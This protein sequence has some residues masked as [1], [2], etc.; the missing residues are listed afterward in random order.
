MNI[1]KQKIKKKVNVKSHLRTNKKTL[2]TTIVQQHQRTD[3]IN[4][5]NEY[6]KSIGYKPEQN[7]VKN[8]MDSN[9]SHAK[10]SD[11]SKPSESGI[12]GIYQLLIENKNK[13]A[14][15]HYFKPIN[16][17]TLISTKNRF[18][19][20]NIQYNQPNTLN[21]N[22]HITINDNNNN[23]LKYNEYVDLQDNLKTQ[24]SNNSIDN[25][26]GFS[27]HREIATLTLGN[28]LKMDHLNDG[29]LR[30]I[31][32]E[33]DNGIKTEQL[34]FISKNNKIK[35]DKDNH[36]IFTGAELPLHENNNMDLTKLSNNHVKEQLSLY[37]KKFGDKA[38]FDYLIGNTDRHNGNFFIQKSN[39][40]NNKELKM[41]AFDHGLTFGNDNDALLNNE[42][43]GYKPSTKPSKFNSQIKTTNASKNTHISEEFKTNL[44]NFIM[45]NMEKTPNGLKQKTNSNTQYKQFI[46]FLVTKI[47]KNEAIAFKDRLKKV[48]SEIF[49]NKKNNLYEILN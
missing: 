1:K 4:I 35:F 7:I 9:L 40:P 19:R 39:D 42:G 49:V 2:T 3:E 31:N 21:S 29:T 47:G 14:E 16:E 12:N 6:M 28:I 41:L 34:G 18:I 20:N 38:V 37:D 45:D 32:I 11:I 24:L 23:K 46:D 5:N 8:A 22:P 13:E 15:F 10:I 26:K 27:A 36:K 30:K 33:N 17:E 44:K 43:Q 25:Y 48:T